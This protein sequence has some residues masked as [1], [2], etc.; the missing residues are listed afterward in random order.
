MEYLLN[1][2]VTYRVHTVEEAEVMHERFKN[3]GRFE[4]VQF[5][6]TTKDIKVKGEVVDQYQVVKMKLIFTNEKDPEATYQ[7]DF[8]EV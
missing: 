4:L 6:Y 3:D 7:L 8:E 1:T 5:S 2:V